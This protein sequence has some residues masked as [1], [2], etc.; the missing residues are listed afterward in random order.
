MSEALLRSLLGL[1][2]PAGH[3]ARLS[4]L[5]FHRVWPTADP[6]YPEAMTGERF[7][8]ICVWLAQFF[9]VLPL[10]EAAQRLRAG[11]LPA[12]AAAI[13]FDDG[14][15]DNHDIALPLLHRRRLPATVFVATAFLD[16]STMWND[17][18]LEA[19]RVCPGDTLVVADIVPTLG[20]PLV[21]RHPLDRRMAAEAI[22]SAIK[23]LPAGER[24]DVVRDI[25][26]RCGAG[27]PRRLM[28]NPEEVR[29]LHR[30]GVLIGAHTVNHPILAGLNRDTARAEILEG[31][32]QLESLIDEPVTLFAYPNGKPGEDY[33]QQAVHLVR[34]LSF[35]AAVTTAWGTAS[36][37]TDPLQLPRFTPWDRT[38]TRFGLRM[39]RNARRRP[40]TLS[41]AGAGTLE[42]ETS[43][44]R[45]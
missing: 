6:M 12:R 31:R 41:G 40:T 45:G 27:K 5:V 33:D 26:R 39:L 2:S 34:E 37:D 8:Q 28:L 44:A 30:Q 24:L 10:D 25:V 21:L 1:A 19:L 14:Y 29:R 32:R 20:S 7:D 9:H 16:G 11:T 4:V 23:Y 3:W 22:I 38:A 43:A 35:H 36:R 13:T 17:T 18:V 15:V 42:L